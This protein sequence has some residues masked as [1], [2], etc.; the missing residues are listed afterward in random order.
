MQPD[1]ERESTTQFNMSLATLAR[2]DR[3]LVSLNDASRDPMTWRS[4]L[5]KL[6]LELRP[7]L[8]PAE[9]EEADKKHNKAHSFE[10]RFD[11]QKVYYDK[12]SPPFLHEWEVWM[13]EELHDKGL[14]MAKSDDP[15]TA[16]GG[17]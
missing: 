2:I 8:S 7:F 9:K 5:S 14:L 12:D 4:N 10:M 1:K 3:I 17:G 11:G 16:L 15:S 13:R 6:H